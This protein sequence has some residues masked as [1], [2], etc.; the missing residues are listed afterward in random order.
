MRAPAIDNKEALAV[1]VREIASVLLG[2]NGAG[3]V[4]T[5]EDGL[6]IVRVLDAAQRSLAKGG[7]RV[8]L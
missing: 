5:G 2:S 3:A 4:A 8:I 7:E 6:E 1:E